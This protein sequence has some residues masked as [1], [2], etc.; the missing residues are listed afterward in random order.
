MKKQNTQNCNA[1]YT[2]SLRAKRSN[3]FVRP[4]LDCRVANAPRNDRLRENG[5][6]LWFILIAIILLGLLTAMLTR[7]GGNTNDTG[8]YERL[9]IKANEIITYGRSLGNGIQ[10]LLSRG[11]SENEIS[12][13]DPLLASQGSFSDHSNPNAPADFSCHIFRPEGAGLEYWIT[14]DLDIYDLSTFPNPIEFYINGL[15]WWHPDSPNAP[16]RD[17]GMIMENLDKNFCIALNRQLGVSN[18][19]DDAPDATAE[20]RGGGAFRGTFSTGFALDREVRSAGGEL[21]NQFSAC[22]KAGKTTPYPYI[23]YQT[24]HFR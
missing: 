8:D 24:L 5:N 21:E 16:T 18:D 13:E 20:S 4:G 9:S 15:G 2:S 23:Y 12:F 22:F 3:L 10:M 7:S 14:T 17:W 1:Y 19:G 11:C 6:A